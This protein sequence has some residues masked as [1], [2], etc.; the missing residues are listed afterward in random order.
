MKHVELPCNNVKCSFICQICLRAKLHRQPFPVSSTQASKPF[1][2]LHVDIWGSYKCKTYD[3][4][5]YF[6]TIVDDCSR[7]TWVHLLSQKSNAFPILR[8]FVT[9]METQFNAV[10]KIIRSNNGLEFKDT[11]AL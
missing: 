8:A 3:G 7:A 10:I 1:E 2:L 11:T 6:L 9:Q 4:F 5:Q